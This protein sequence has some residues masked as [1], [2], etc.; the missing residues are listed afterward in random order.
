[1]FLGFCTDGTPIMN[2]THALLLHT[3]VKVLGAIKVVERLERWM[4]LRFP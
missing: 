1:M 2:L 4:G 3:L